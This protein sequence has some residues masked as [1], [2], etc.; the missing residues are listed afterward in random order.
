LLLRLLRLAGHLRTSLWAL[1]SLCLLLRR[2][3]T[4]LLLE[5]LLLLLLHLRLRASRNGS[6]H[7]GC[8]GLVAPELR[9]ERVD[10]REGESAKKSAAAQ[11]FDDAP[12]P[13]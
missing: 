13:G 10:L 2:R 11:R 8:C 7:G 4:L 9:G 12:A 3:T 5:R 1:L 6:L